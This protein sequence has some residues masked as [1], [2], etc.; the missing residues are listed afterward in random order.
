MK[1]SENRWGKK[2]PRLADKGWRGDNL[3]DAMPPGFEDPLSGNPFGIL[4]PGMGVGH[5]RNLED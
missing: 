3:H 5:F 4:E 2:R 1:T